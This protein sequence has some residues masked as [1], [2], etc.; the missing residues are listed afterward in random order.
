MTTYAPST[1]TLHVLSGSAGRWYVLEGRKV[2][3][4]HATAAAA[5]DAL[6]IL[7]GDY[8]AGENWADWY[9]D[10]DVP[11]GCRPCA[12]ARAEDLFMERQMGLYDEAVRTLDPKFIPYLD[13]RT[14]WGDANEMAMHAMEAWAD[15]NR[16]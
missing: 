2:V 11:N 6:S 4:R 13:V 1:P 15:R 8:E 10:H 5:A 3:S 9:C 16:P 7:N 14:G 12:A